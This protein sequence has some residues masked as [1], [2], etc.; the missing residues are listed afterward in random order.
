MTTLTDQNTVGEIAARWP[1]A[2]RLFEKYQIDY[3]C[4]GKLSLAEACQGRG[5]ESEALRSELEQL[6]APRTVSA[7]DWQNAPLAELIDHI[8]TRHHEYLKLELP[9]LASI[10]QKVLQAHAQNHGE[11]LA[12]LSRIFAGMKGEL[13][14]HMA[15]E[16]MILFP[17]IRRLAEARRAGAEAPPSHCG[18]ILNPIRVMEFEHD[19]AGRALSELREL[20]QDYTLPP[21]ACNTW[22]ALYFELQELEADLHQHIHLEN[23]ILFPRAVE[24]ERS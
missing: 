10:S 23:N 8:L 20:T 13:E 4:G 12:P 21:E 3:C 5:I 15:K 11:T 9:R 7:R 22:R 18:S 16:E 24:L 6:G 1:A 19:S 2:V 14:H 17:I